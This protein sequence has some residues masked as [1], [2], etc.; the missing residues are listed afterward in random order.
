MS[1]SCILSCD[2]SIA[3]YFSTECDL[4]LPISVYSSCLRLLPCVPDFSTFPSITDVRR[5]FLRKPWSIRLA[6]LCFSVC[7]MFL[8]SSTLC[9]TSFFTRSVQLIFSIL[10]HHHISKLWTYNSVDK[11]I[12]FG[13]LVDLYHEPN[14]SCF[15][16]VSFHFL[17]PFTPLSY[18][19]SV[20]VFWPTFIFTSY[21]F[22]AC[23]ISH[24]PNLPLCIHLNIQRILWIVELLIASFSPIFYYFISPRSTYL[25]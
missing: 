10:L 22:H 17:F 9:N 11:R 24:P 8:S 18:R 13:H 19:T 5:Q 7:R 23:G 20:D 2:R 16:E 4:V 12:T 15:P 25:T 21:V 14:L 1:P 3:C 6:F